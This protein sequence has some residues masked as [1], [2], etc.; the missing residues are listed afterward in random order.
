MSLQK[1]I[2]VTLVLL[3]ALITEVLMATLMI[4]AFFVLLWALIVGEAGLFFGATMVMSL[5]FVVLLWAADWGSERP[6]L[7]PGQNLKT[8]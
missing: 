1:K 2:P 6:T 5:S 3:G 4:F 7:D 8:T